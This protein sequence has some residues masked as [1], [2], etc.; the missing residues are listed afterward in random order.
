MERIPF[1]PKE[2]EVVGYCPA[3]NPFAPPLPIYNSPI[4][5][6]EN[7][8]L[9]YKGE[10]P[11]WMPHSFDSYLFMPECVPDNWC[12][13]MVTSSKPTKPEMY[14]GK[15]MF[16]VEW[17]YVPQVGG[18]MVRP[19]KPYVEDLEHWED[20]VPFP[21]LDEWDW[22]GCAETFKERLHDGRFVKVSLMSGMFERL[23]SFV[24]MTD[25]LIAL[26]DEDQQ[27]AVHRLFGKLCDLYDDMFARFKKYF[28][29]D[30][31]W[32]HDDWGSQRSPF[33]SP[34]TVREMIAPYIKRV[35]DS[36]HKYGMIIDFHSCGHIEALVPIMI[37]CGVDSWNGQPMNDKLAVA[38]AYPGQIV[39]DALPEKMSIECSEDEIR[40]SV[41]KFVNDFKGLSA[42]CTMNYSS[43]PHPKF[44]EILYE[45]SR[46]AFNEV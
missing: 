44:Y 23:I 9:L 21:N 3:F 2:L 22:A 33:F 20:Y 32:F 26:V 19:G 1:D 36:A 5:R 17:E 37:D 11:L 4:S 41:T 35:C 43:P 29:A 15:D 16:G 39:V 12:R 27:E 42:Y 13:G 45:V 38:K 18:S 40:E 31:V 34:S 24:D 8:W 25:A 7:H 14:G 30:G 28:D 6:K 46:K 10:T